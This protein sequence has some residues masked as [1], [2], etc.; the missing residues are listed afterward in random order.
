MRVTPEVAYT[1]ERLKTEVARSMGVHPMRITG[2]RVARRSIDA[3]QKRVM[4]NLLV[5]VWLDTV[6]EETSLVVPVKYRP[7]ASDAPQAIVVGAGPAGL[8]AA[9]R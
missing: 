2:M 7:L 6:P 4:V 3:R 8:F 1:E 5:R 9:L